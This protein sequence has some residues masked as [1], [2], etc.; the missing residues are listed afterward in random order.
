[1]P[2][3]L[4]TRDTNYIYIL[5]CDLP[6]LNQYNNIL[7]IHQTLESAK[8]TYYDYYYMNDSNDEIYIRSYRKYGND[9]FKQSNPI[10][11]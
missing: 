6:Q 2:F 3:D 9:Y 7:S 4:N 1:M 5:M 11:F 8:S 10:Y